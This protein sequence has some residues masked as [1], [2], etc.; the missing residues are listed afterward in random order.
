MLAVYRELQVSEPDRTWQEPTAGV[1]QTQCLSYGASWSLFGTC[2]VLKGKTQTSH[3]ELHSTPGWGRNATPHVRQQICGAKAKNNE[4]II[5][6]K[7]LEL[8]INK[9]TQNE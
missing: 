7:Q 9:E 6:K 1:R 5:T 3:K 2:A 4:I 8:T